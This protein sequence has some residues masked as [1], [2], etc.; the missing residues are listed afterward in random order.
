MTA[1]TTVRTVR[2]RTLRIAAAALTAVA[3]LTLTA[4][5]GSDAGTK[6]ANRA[7]SGVAAAEPGGAGASAGVQGA[8]PEAGSGAQGSGAQ[9]GSEAKGGSKSGGA[10]GGK[11]AGGSHAGGGKAA[12]GVQRCHTSNL[13]AVFATGEDAVPDPDAD[14]G[15]TTSIVLTNKGSR[16]CKIGGFAGI[17]L[18]PDAGGPG[19]PLARSSAQHGSITLAPGESTDFTLNLGMAKENAEDSWLPRTVAVT[20]PDETTS[21]T[22]KWPWGPLV[23]QRGATH[24]ATFVNPIG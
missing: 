5:S 23:D 4:C 15:T 20:P 1:D 16:A 10:G 13:T 9:G 17:D 18:R 7:D 3:G 8:E 19:W 21:L 14:G 6:T 22:L 11:R 2:R 12:A 24:P